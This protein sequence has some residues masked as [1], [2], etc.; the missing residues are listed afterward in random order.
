MAQI[1]ATTLDKTNLLA[2]GSFALADAF[3]PF[4]IQTQS[5][6]VCAWWTTSIYPSIYPSI[7]LSIMGL[8]WY[9]EQ[10]IERQSH[11]PSGGPPWYDFNFDS[12]GRNSIQYR[13]DSIMI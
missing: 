7:H 5:I 12:R 4:P 13:F 11:A 2:H 3:G 10:S 9:T 1:K 8:I 6:L